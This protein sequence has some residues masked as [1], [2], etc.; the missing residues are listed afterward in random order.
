MAEDSKQNSRFS[1]TFNMWDPML[2]DSYTEFLKLLFPA[3]LDPEY[4]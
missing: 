4:T 1:L 3:K 2:Y